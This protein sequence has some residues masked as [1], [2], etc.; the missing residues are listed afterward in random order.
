LTTRIQIQDKEE[1]ISRTRTRARREG[2]DNNK[3]ATNKDKE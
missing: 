1:R 2:K 3:G